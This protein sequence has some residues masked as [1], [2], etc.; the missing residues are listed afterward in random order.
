[1]SQNTRVCPNC[2]TPEVRAVLDGRPTVNLDPITGC[3]VECLI[4]VGEGSPGDAAG[5]ERRAVR[6]PSGRGKERRMT[7]ADI[8]RIFPHKCYGPLIGAT[9]CAICRWVLERW[10]GKL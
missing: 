8:Q 1:M 10:S 7:H 5:G 2:Q 9:R 4:G 6:Q 3:C